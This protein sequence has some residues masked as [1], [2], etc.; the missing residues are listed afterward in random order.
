VSKNPTSK[1]TYFV[2]RVTVFGAAIVFLLVLL[3]LFAG[4]LSS[5]STPVEAAPIPIP[6]ATPAFDCAAS[7]PLPQSFID[8]W[9]L[10]FGALDFN[11]TIIDLVENCVYSMGE[12]TSVFPTASTGKLIVATGVLELVAGGTLDY[13]SVESDM[14]LMITQSDNNAA[15]RLFVVIG[16]NDALISIIERYGLTVTTT[17]GAWG[18]VLTNSADQANLLNQVVGTQASSLPEAQR[19]TLRDLLTKVNPEQAWGAGNVTIPDWTTAVKN[20]WYLSVPGDRPPE[21]LWRV[22]T[23]GYVWDQTSKPRWIFTGY[24][25]TWE[26]QERGI[27]AWNAIST[28]LSNTLAIR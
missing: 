3:R 28:Q 17:G 25:N 15:D 14:T 10:E 13:A 7:T 16:R 4:F 6:V 8:S 1:R 22:N 18:T 21:G 27:S 9:V 24:S 20:G 2:R 19:V 11:T 12:P 5:E 26:T 23:L